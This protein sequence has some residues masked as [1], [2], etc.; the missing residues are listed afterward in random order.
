MGE[1]RAFKE[2]FL[3]F[4]MIFLAV[5][6]SFFAE[7]IRE[8]FV[9]RSQEK[10]YV[11]SLYDDLSHDE[12][13]LPELLDS[14]RGKIREAADLQESLPKA[15]TSSD[16]TQ[17]YVDFRHIIRQLGVR[18]FVSD[19]TIAQLRNSGGMRLIRTGK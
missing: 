1:K 6:L 16:A 8:R 14:I 11:R 15:T 5:T 4:L 18:V 17:I 2:Y 13:N 12:R 10:E 3:E 19:R 7:N 9:E